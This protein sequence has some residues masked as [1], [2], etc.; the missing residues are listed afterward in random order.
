MRD[1]IMVL[2]GFVRGVATVV[3]EVTTAPLATE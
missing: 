1:F 2:E 3:A